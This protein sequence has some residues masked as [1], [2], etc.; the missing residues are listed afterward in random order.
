MYGQF[1]KWEQLAPISK[2]IVNRI[3]CTVSKH[4]NLNFSLLPFDIQAD[5]DFVIEWF[6]HS[7]WTNE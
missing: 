5:M 1:F 7:I 3:Q 6:M 2:V 4:G